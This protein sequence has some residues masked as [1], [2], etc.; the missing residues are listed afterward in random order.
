VRRDISQN[1]LE[2]KASSHEGQCIPAGCRVTLPRRVL[3]TIYVNNNHAYIVGD[4]AQT[5]RPIVYALQNFDR[6][7]PNLVAPATHVSQWDLSARNTDLFHLEHIVELQV[8]T[9]LKRG[10]SVLCCQLNTNIHF[11]RCVSYYEVAR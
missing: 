9:I 1:E 7:F 4:F 5:L 3:I 2:T 10:H 6:N 11:R 8:S